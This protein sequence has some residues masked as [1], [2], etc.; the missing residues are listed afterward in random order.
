MRMTRIAA[1]VALLVA[2]AG[3]CADAASAKGPDFTV[4]YK[5][6]SK[7]E[8]K[9]LKIGFQ[10]SGFLGSS[11][12]TLDNLPIQ[13][14]KLRLQVP[15]KNLAKIEFISVGKKGKEVK[16]RLTS[17]DGKTLNEG[18]VSHENKKI[19]WKCTHPFAKSEAT[20]EPSNIRE[21]IL[22]Q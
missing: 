12:K 22:K 13:T 7:A 17:R 21:I 6:G 14:A 1:V 20:L 2:S 4:V 8:L 19:I 16:V 5:D 9:A 11:F 18:N 10:D 3:A 15:L